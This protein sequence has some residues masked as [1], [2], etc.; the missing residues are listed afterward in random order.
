M[1]QGLLQWLTYRRWPFSMNWLLVGM[2]LLSACVH[3]GPS[4][5]VVSPT[6]SSTS[7][8]IPPG[9]G[10]GSGSLSPSVFIGPWSGESNQST[11]SALRADAGT[12]R[13]QYK[14]DVPK[15]TVITDA[16]VVYV[17]GEAVTVPSPFSIV[18][19]LRASD[20]AVLWKTSLHTTAVSW[21]FLWQKQ[22]FALDVNGGTIFSQQ[23]AN[24]KLLWSTS[25]SP[26]FSQQTILSP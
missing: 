18:Y 5:R 22:L 19:A 10:P 2:F 13:W 11:I 23:S 12:L 9:S 1:K 3:P 4:P 6:V 26:V 21:L 15:P 8:C 17:A 25:T 24:G 16:G 20:G 7:T 14:T